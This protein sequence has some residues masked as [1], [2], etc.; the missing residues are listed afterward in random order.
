MSVSISERDINGWDV[1]GAGA[2]VVLT[3]L[4]ARP[5]D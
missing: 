2:V 3:V 5:A 1:V 4:V